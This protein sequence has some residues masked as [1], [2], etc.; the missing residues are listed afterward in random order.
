MPPV[1]DQPIVENFGA[2]YQLDGLFP[3][4]DTVLVT[5]NQFIIQVPQVSDL[6]DDNSELSDVVGNLLRA[7]FE[8]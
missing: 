8:P 6:R 7:M 1:N 2:V 5:L 3:V 4:L